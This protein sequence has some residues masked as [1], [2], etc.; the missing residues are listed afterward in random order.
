MTSPI[1]IL[2]TTGH[3]FLEK[4][5]SLAVEAPPTLV[6]AGVPG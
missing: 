6:N 4:S 3:A 2:R 1:R 5:D